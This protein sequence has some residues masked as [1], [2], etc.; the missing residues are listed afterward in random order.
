MHIL[1]EVRDSLE[2]EKNVYMATLMITLNKDLVI[3]VSK[4]YLEGR[5]SFCEIMY[6][7]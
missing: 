1:N 6:I 7:S 5:V 4:L 2:P 3:N